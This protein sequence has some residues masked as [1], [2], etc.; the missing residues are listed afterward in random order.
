[1]STCK[2]CLCK[3]AAKSSAA[4]K[5]NASDLWLSQLKYLSSAMMS[6]KAAAAAASSPPIAHRWWQ[7]KQGD[8]S[9]QHCT[10]MKW[11]DW[12]LAH[13]HLHTLSL[14]PKCRTLLDSFFS[15]AIALCCWAT[16][17]TRAFANTSTTGHMHHLHTQAH[18]HTHFNLLQTFE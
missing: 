12:P 18:T 6:W 3:L 17:F 4:G 13:L 9:V 2:C 11:T 5:A 1:M 10:G 14:H 8:R 16:S 7:S 15:A